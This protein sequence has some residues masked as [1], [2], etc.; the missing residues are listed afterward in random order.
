VNANRKERAN[1][2]SMLNVCLFGE[3]F[4][5]PRGGQVARAQFESGY[6]A[7]IAYFLSAERLKS[8]KSPP[9]S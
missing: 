2:S 9:N 8:A 1:P 7:I 6:L 3:I 5:A 4:A